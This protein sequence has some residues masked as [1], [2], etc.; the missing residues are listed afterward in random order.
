[1]ADNLIQRGGFWHVRLDIP[2][3]VQAAFGN[4][5]ILSQTLHTGSRA[6]AMRLRLPLLAK[7]KAEIQAVREQK[8]MSADEWRL[9]LHTAGQ[10]TLSRRTQAVQHIYTPSRPGE[11]KPIDLSFLNDFPEIY[12][13]LVDEGRP[14]LATRLITWAHTYVNKIETG[15]TH[16][17]GIA[18]QND[19]I[20]ITTSI[21]VMATVDEYMLSAEE[22]QE[23]LSIAFNPSL[24]TPKS[25]ITKA[26]LDAWAV[27]LETQIKMPKTRDAHVGRMQRFSDF[28]T[29]EGLPI[30]FDTVD[31]WLVSI[32]P[33]RKTRA[34]YISSG[35]SFWKWAT[36]YNKQ[37]R[38]QFGAS[39]CP[40][41]N[42]DLPRQGDAAGRSYVAFT[43]VEVESLHT[44]ALENG[45]VDL[46]FLIAIGAYTGARIEE[47]GRIRSEDIMVDPDGSP[48]GFRINASKT[49]A[50][51]RE[52]PLHS[53]IV[54]LF[55]TLLKEA[56]ANDGYLLKGGSSK[57]GVRLNGLSKRFST[58]KSRMGFSD[59]H[60]FHSI[61]KTTTTELH[62]LGVTLEILPYILGHET[63][64]FT[65]DV[66]SAGPSFAQKRDAINKLE[67]SFSD[68]N[69][70]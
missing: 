43:R 24:Y 17:D 62:R 41:D 3:D 21:E 63:K 15:M 29:A 48:V 32:S 54:P 14:D 35:R 52:V 28:L 16:S 61:R 51:I 56:S 36:K 31:R 34:N 68:E 50:G 47:I 33:A 5:R 11:S 53:A 8:K 64:T 55:S 69:R 23:A 19:L 9:A 66:Y 18:L 49:A 57:Y 59:L 70:P 65:L 30:D 2:K 37:F 67:Y 45:D 7:W 40:F 39:Q 22:E 42:H 12:K 44:T 10:D 1:M 4:R 46:S 6:E 58:L 27:F 26:M 60:C 20:D 38:E 13:H 25:P